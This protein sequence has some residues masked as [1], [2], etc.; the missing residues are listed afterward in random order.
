M[1]D[2]TPASEPTR[3]PVPNAILVDNP[4]RHISKSYILLFVVTAFLSF[5]L[6]LLVPF[7]Y[8]QLNLSIYSDADANGDL[9]IREYASTILQHDLANARPDSSGTAEQP[10]VSGYAATLLR[11]K[12]LISF[13]YMHQMQQAR[14]L[15]PRQFL[16]FASVVSLLLSIVLVFVI[17]LVRR[18]LLRTVVIAS[19]FL[20]A[21]LAMQFFG[22]PHIN[23]KFHIVIGLTYVFLLVVSDY[24]QTLDLKLPPSAVQPTDPRWPGYL[25]ALQYKHRFWTA[26]L[27]VSSIALLTLIATVSFN[28]YNLLL[29]VFGESFVIYPLTGILFSVGLGVLGAFVGIFRPIRRHM[30]AIED[31]MAR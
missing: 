10:S 31:A 17:A 27:N 22:L 14:D 7:L 6:L 25:S 9:L 24:L 13:D 16:A 12:H 19:I 18:S 2:T 11:D 4:S 15:R 3:P 21:L 28:A 1:V 26:I 8:D 5:W 29:S 23:Q 20:A 30:L